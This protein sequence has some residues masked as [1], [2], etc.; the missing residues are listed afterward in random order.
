[1]CCAGGS[2]GSTIAVGDAVV[3]DY[4]SRI[5]PAPSRWIGDGKV[6]VPLYMLAVEALLARTVV[7][8]FYQP[9]S[10]PDLRPRGVLEEDSRHR[11][12]RCPRRR[13]RR[14]GSPRAVGRSPLDGSRGGREARRGEVEPG[15]E[16]CAPGGGCSYP[17]I[18][19]CR[20]TDEQSPRP[21]RSGALSLTAAAGSGKTSVF[22]ERFVAAVLEDRLSPS[23][24]LAITFTDRA[25]GELR[26]RVRSRFLALGE[27]AAARDTEAAHVSTIHGFCA[28][29][30]AAH[31][32]AAGLD[33]G[34][35]VLD[36]G[37]AGRLRS[38]AFQTA[39]QEFVSGEDPDAVALVATYGPIACG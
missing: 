9:L 8:G 39:L 28:S 20:L 17:S 29:L 30:L 26:E 19:R 10:G 16:S 35:A 24:I 34:F 2:T 18:C 32:L 31:P 27:R 5:V 23:Q 4:K 15:P 21:S 13:A 22:V 1:M 38:L 37:V 6:Q 12:R 25:A 3:V 33:P 7:G 14:R 11:A 36:E